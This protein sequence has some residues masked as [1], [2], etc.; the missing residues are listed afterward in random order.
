MSRREFLQAGSLG[1]LGLS[2]ADL[3]RLRA[4]GAATD[5]PVR[6][7]VVLWLWGGPSHIDTF[8]M[9]PA[10]PDE[11]RG[12]WTPTRTTVPGTQICELLPRC[13]KL[14]HQYAIIRSMHCTSN[15]HGVAGTIGLTGSMAGALN[16]GGMLATGS[17]RPCTGSIV[18]RFRSPRTE[19]TRSGSSLAGAATS[20]RS[21][22]ADLSLGVQTTPDGSASGELPKFMVV[23]GRLHQGKKPIVGEGGGKLG[24]LY[25]PFR[26][27]YDPEEGARAPS[28]AL[29]EELPVTR[30][31]DRRTL[32]RSVDQVEHRLEARRSVRSLDG[33]YDQAFS[34]LTAGPAKKVFDL[35]AEPDRLRDRY[36][37]FR[38]GQSCLL[39]RRLVEAAVPFVQV[40]WSAHVEAE[41]DAGDGGWDMHYRNFEVLGDRHL[42]MFDQTFTALIE[43]LDQRGLL[44]S[45]LL[46]AVG[47]FGRT[48]K[49][50]PHAGR[51]HWEKCYS[52]V[53]AGGGVT[54]GRII[55]ASDALAQHPHERPT[56]P[57][58]IAATILDRCGIS[59][60]QLQQFDVQP[61]GRV[62]H[63]LF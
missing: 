48:P 59:I 55:G 19:L 20:A 29:S 6:S 46:V 47:E 13:A 9:K 15:D 27:E 18:A 3:L 33:F 58:D 51:D 52:A 44:A 26:L 45:T 1:V 39:A 11:Y 21:P 41:E 7:V 37:R 14:A 17:A 22:N 32:L 23:G 8:D 53:L 30:L 54:G 43:D 28:L 4:I 24:A 12:P 63:E 40:N 49:I 61:E 57:A 31:E 42:W 10:A 35:S 36:G 25:D 5:A 16:L 34:L 2:W 50:N 56:T 38:F 62:I 60:A